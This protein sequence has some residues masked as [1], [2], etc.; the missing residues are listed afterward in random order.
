MLRA[1]LVVLWPSFVF[2]QNAPPC[3]VVVS[4]ESALRSEIS[5][6]QTG[7]GKVLCIAPGRLTLS[8]RISIGKARS[9]T[10]AARIYITARDGPGSVTIDANG[11]EE[12]FIVTAS[13]LSLT[14][15]VITGGA[16]H[17][18]KVDPPSVGVRIE[19]N[20]LTNN[21]AAGDPGG[22]YSAIKACCRVRDLVVTRN[23]ITE[24]GS[25]SPNI[26]GFDCNGCKNA[27]VSFNEIYDELPD[28]SSLTAIQLKSGSENSDINGN[29]IFNAFIGVSLGGFGDPVTWGGLPADVEE[30]GGIVRNN[31][32]YN[33][34]D[35]GITVI[36][37]KDGRIYHNTL[38]NNGFTPDVR[39]VARNL[40]FRNNIFDRPLNFRD[41][42]SGRQSSNIVLNAP[43]D[44]A[45]FVDA[46]NGDFHLKQSAAAVDQGAVVSGDVD[47]DRDGVARPQGGGFDVG[48]YELP[49][50]DGLPPAPP[51][52]L[53]IVR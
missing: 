52:N 39:V 42:T 46:P 5:S 38:F 36:K 22:Q 41:G 25:P 21:T 53:R 7:T 44:G 26:Q 32:I 35:A 34:R 27:E 33:C 14:D 37:A 49:S 18:I 6:I 45:L 48:A 19:R 12:A 3:D 16:Y 43:N 9:G 29:K 15:L 24:R 8:N 1:L 40:D 30:Q 11:H 2:A 31:V 13:Y 4:S 17:A 20:H 51:K 23:R 28:S 10:S 50:G 47:A